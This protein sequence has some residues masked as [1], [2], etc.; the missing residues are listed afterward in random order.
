[1]SAV[2][3]DPCSHQE[4]EPGKEEK[5]RLLFS[6]LHYEAAVYCRT[7]TA[8]ILIVLEPFLNLMSREFY[9]EDVRPPHL[10]R[11]FLARCERILHPS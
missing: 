2:T 7:T 9:D 1:M 4:N 10:V 3:M 6:C 8:L 5:L 11:I